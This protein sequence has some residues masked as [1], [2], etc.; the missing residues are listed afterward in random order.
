MSLNLPIVVTYEDRPSAV[1]GVELL[2][3]SLERYSP[4]LRVEV[5]SPLEII[6]DRLANLPRL[7]FIRT[8]DLVR[9][10]W[11]VKPVILLR[12]LTMHGRAFWLDT[13]VI[14]SGDIGSLIN[15][16]DHDAFVVGQ[17]FRASDKGGGKMRAL[18][19]GLTPSRHLPYQVNS[20][21]IL[22]CQQHRVVLEKWSALLMDIQ[23]QEAQ[24]R[25]I[26]ERPIA[27]VSDQDAL[28]GL[29]ASKD[30]SEL[31]LDYFRTGYDMIQHCGANGYHVL[32]RLSRPFGNRP[33]FVHMLGRYKPWS[34]EKVPPARRSVADY[35]HMVCFELSPFFEAAQPFSAYL[36]RPGWLRMRTLPARILNSLFAGNVA[37]RGLPLAFVAWV[38]ALMGRRPKL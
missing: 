34:F 25:P 33:V 22:A 9:R 20:G 3:R 13:D 18:A 36:D 15:R 30:F 1:P 6:A 38:A 23:Y 12:A 31:K 32:E 37:L 28:W 29:L 4:S 35:F 26:S 24:R 10:G 27:F 16:F 5:Y 8:D 11:N 2:A 19:Y 7:K 21:S 17:E 14:I